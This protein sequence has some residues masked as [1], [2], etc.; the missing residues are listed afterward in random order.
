MTVF[1]KYLQ[2]PQDQAAFVAG[3]PK[4]CY[5]TFYPFRLFADG[6]ELVF[7]PVTIL[8]GGNGSGKST[9]LN[10][11]ASM[12]QLSRET[13]FNQSS[14]WDQYIQQCRIIMGD[15]DE[16]APYC[17]PHGSRIIASDD[18]FRHILELRGYNDNIDRQRDRTIGQY[19]T[20]RQD[21]SF[22]F[23]SN[24]EGALEQLSRRVAARKK[25][26]SEFVRTFVEENRREYSNGESAIRYFCSALSDNAINLLDEPENSMSPAFQL[27]L[28][29]LLHNAARGGCQLIIATHSP[30]LLAMPGA[31]IYDIDRVFQ[32]KE[33]FELENPR[34]FYEFF[35]K[36]A[37][38]FES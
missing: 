12:L 26:C 22:Q 10:I 3:Q 11:I 7:A 14:F 38:K 27:E 35:R 17:V 32:P 15:D 24:N 18:V 8:Y 31:K 30:L 16:G 28:V 33:W 2:L 21:P 36:H 13:P 5:T 1:L 23:N 20:D 37:D 4:T 9:L 19:Y 34:I 29:D 25:T 6:G